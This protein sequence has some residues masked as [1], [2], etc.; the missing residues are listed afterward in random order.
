VNTIKWIMAVCGGLFMLEPWRRPKEV[1]FIPA[2]NVEAEARCNLHLASK[3]EGQRESF[4]S[5][6]LSLSC[7]A[8]RHGTCNC[9]WKWM[10]MAQNLWLKM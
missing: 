9:G 5:S 7:L 6:S 2:G 10:A 8:G 4:E 1:V 3:E